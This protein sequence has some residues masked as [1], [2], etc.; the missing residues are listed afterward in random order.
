MGTAWLSS[1]KRT[2][3]EQERDGPGSHLVGRLSGGGMANLGGHEDRKL[4]TRGW[5]GIPYCLGR[6][7]PPF[8]VSDDTILAPGGDVRRIFA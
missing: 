6:T 8:I 7:L 2:H 5:P 4:Y 1:L 3:E